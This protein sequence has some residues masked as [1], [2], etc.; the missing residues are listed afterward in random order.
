MNNNWAQVIHDESQKS[1]F[2]RTD[3][4][5]QKQNVG[6]PT[7]SQALARSKFAEDVA[8]KLYFNC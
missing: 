5:A 2:S 8:D 3:E 1:A 4:L 6:Q 7:V